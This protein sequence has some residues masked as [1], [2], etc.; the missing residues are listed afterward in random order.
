MPRG[1][2]F[3][4]N[5]QKR[6]GR[7]YV[8]HVPLPNPGRAFTRLMCTDLLYAHTLI[9]ERA[10]SCANKGRPKV[11]LREAQLVP[12]NAG[13]A[14]SVSPSQMAMSTLH[15]VLSFRLCSCR[16]RPVIPG[17]RIPPPNICVHEGH[18]WCTRNCFLRKS[19]AS[20]CRIRVWRQGF[21]HRGSLWL[22]HWP[23]SLHLN[24]WTRSLPQPACTHCY[25]RQLPKI[26]V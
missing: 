16:C 13:K 11:L 14:S 20:G 17:C 22:Q 18:L 26:L 9:K 21:R 12:Y 10:L 3:P 1:S 7:D 19:D 8:I 2:R 5:V 6:Q 23:E 24:C 15:L 4:C 25:H